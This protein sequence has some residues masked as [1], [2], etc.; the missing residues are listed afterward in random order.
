MNVSDPLLT[1]KEASAYCRMTVGQLAQLRYVGRGP[2]FL[3]PTPRTILYR[4][5]TLD[6]WLDASQRSKALS[7][8]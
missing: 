1:V 5:S 3:N 6:T 4:R 8:Q 2:V 7:R